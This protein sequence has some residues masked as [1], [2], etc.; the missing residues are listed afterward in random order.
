MAKTARNNGG[1][2]QQTPTEAAMRHEA[3]AQRREKN[4]WKAR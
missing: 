2:S 4:R 1:D 3:A